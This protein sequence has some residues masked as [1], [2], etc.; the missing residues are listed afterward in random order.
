M[1]VQ[2]DYRNEMRERFRLGPLAIWSYRVFYRYAVHSPHPGHETVRGEWWPL[3][4]GTRFS[5]RGAYAAGSKATDEHTERA[6]R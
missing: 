1:K 4:S 5:M 3:T 6:A 2:Y